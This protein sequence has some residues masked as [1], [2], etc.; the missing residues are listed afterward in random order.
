MA[1]FGALILELMGADSS[2]VWKRASAKAEFLVVKDDT[3]LRFDTNDPRGMSEAELGRIRIAGDGKSMELGGE[4][5]VRQDPMREEIGMLGFDL[6]RQ[7]ETAKGEESNRLRGAVACAFN[8]VAGA[9]LAYE[10]ILHEKSKYRD[11]ARE[12]LAELY[13]RN[14]MTTK[15]VEY[16]RFT[17]RFFFR[18]LAKYPE[19]T[20][21]HRGVARVQATREENGHLLLPLTVSGKSARYL[22]DTGGNKTLLRMSEAQRLGLKLE[23]QHISMQNGITKFNAHLAII[24][25]LEVGPMHL[26]NVQVWVTPD[27]RLDWP[28]VVGIDVLLKWETIRWGADNM[29]EIG[30]VGDAKEIAKANLCFRHLQVFAD[31]DAYGEKLALFLDTGT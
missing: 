15:A 14:S 3:G 17:Q 23:S 12:R 8:D 21:A 30:F 22:M 10:S 27:E 11:E 9:E 26:A 20:V 24:P 25:T 19:M 5:W 16:Y 7:L 1:L 6:R 2:G 31:A 13:W 28:G 18:Q 4:R 29:V